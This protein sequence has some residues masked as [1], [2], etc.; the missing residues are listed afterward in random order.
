MYIQET[1]MNI[2]K[3]G[4]NLTKTLVYT[5]LAEFISTTSDLSKIGGYPVLFYTVN[6]GTDVCPIV[7]DG[8]N[9]EAIF[10]TGANEQGNSFDRTFSI[11]AINELDDGRY[12]YDFKANKVIYDFQQKTLVEHGKNDWSTIPPIHSECGFSTTISV[13]F[14]PDQ[15][16]RTS[17]FS[18]LSDVPQSVLTDTVTSS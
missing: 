3:S 14:L 10:T 6:S 12:I 1:K 18:C 5:R 16:R 17:T 2:F 8:K 9:L 7:K 13:T 15:T 4:I 11:K